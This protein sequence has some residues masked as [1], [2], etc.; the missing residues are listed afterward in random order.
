ML[1]V[2]F[3]GQSYRVPWWWLSSEHSSSSV[4]WCWGWGDTHMAFGEWIV[5]VPHM[6]LADVKGGDVVAVPLPDPPSLV[7]QFPEQW[8]HEYC[9]SP[10][11][12]DWWLQKDCYVP[13]ETIH[14]PISLGC[15]SGI[16]STYALRYLLRSEKKHFSL[17]NG[18]NNDGVE[19]NFSDTVLAPVHGFR[20]IYTSQNSGHFRTRD[21]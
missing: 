8:W 6:F 4:K 9:N 14:L 7:Q 21:K 15:F 2:G 10:L 18:T 13:Q 5:Y 17:R 12:E 16:L 1:Y 19:D 3:W 20:E 11:N